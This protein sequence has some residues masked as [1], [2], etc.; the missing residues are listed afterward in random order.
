MVFNRFSDTLGRLNNLLA[1]LSE[2]T[3]PTGD[4]ESKIPP[5]KHGLNN[6]IKQ[7]IDEILDTA[8]Q[9]TQEL[10]T[11]RSQMELIVERMEEGYIAFDLEGHI[12]KLN[13]TA[14]QKILGRPASELIGISYLEAFQETIEPEFHRQFQAVCVEQRPVQFEIKWRATG[15]WLALRGYPREEQIEFFVRDISE[16]KRAEIELHS[17]ARFAEENPNPVLRIDQQG[18]VLYGNAS[19]MQLLEAH[20]CRVGGPAPEFLR[21]LALEALHDGQK[22]MA[23]YPYDGRV[24]AFTIVPFLEYGYVNLYGSDMTEHREAEEQLRVSNDRLQNVLSNITDAYF[25]L[26]DQ[27]RLVDYNAVAEQDFL[28][29]PKS[30][31]IGKGF[32][33]EFPQTIGNEHY[34][35]FHRAFET[36]QPVH[37]EAI[38]TLA[39]KWYEVHAYPRAGRL[40]IYLRNIDERKQTEN[41]LKTALSRAE[42][43]QTEALTIQDQALAAA[44]LA[45]RRERVLETVFNAM[46]EGVTLFDIQGK[47]A[48]VN[49]SARSYFGIDP[50]GLDPAA[51]LELLPMHEPDGRPLRLENLP[52][53]LALQ[54]QTVI[55]HQLRFINPHGEVYNIVASAAPLY[56]DNQL[57][58]A[59]L[60][61]RDVT[62]RE[63][64]LRRLRE[65]SERFDVAL[66]N[67]PVSVYTLD[68]DMRFTWAYKPVYNF[69]VDQML[70]RRDDELLP[71]EEVGELVAI[72]RQ[73]LESGEGK[74]TEIELALEGNKRFFD[75]TIE[76]VRGPEGV[77][78]GLTVAWIDITGQRRLEA[79]AIERIAQIEIQREILRQREQERMEVARDLHDGPLQDMIGLS[80]AL[81]DMVNTDDKTERLEKIE[82]IQQSLQSQINNIRIFCSELRP[83]ALAP[84]GVERA[85][86]A[87]LESVQ[88]KNSQIQFYLDMVKDG[89]TLPEETRMALFRV[90]QEAVNNVVKHSS[91]TDT[92]VRF[93]LDEEQVELEIRDNGQGFTRPANL[94]NLA[95][96]GHLGL[97]GMQERVE[98]VGGALEVLSMPGEG[99]RVRVTIRRKDDLALA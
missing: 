66:R 95:R 7:R 77:V 11:V 22:K 46:T 98:A 33:D 99:T 86:R 62:E 57:I 53:Q 52:A 9:S 56:I 35:Q 45:L 13:K 58:G 83:P 48:Q 73:V 82:E 26:D 51:Y 2:L 72:K 79:E 18:I 61:W 65:I 87:H 60:V 30:E 50:T 59:V 68:R 67:A 17:Q 63:Q 80:F 21:G 40:E 49:P 28:F 84:F 10:A 64:L 93:Y 89:N 41:E 69:T 20:G 27:W 39:S 91:A 85:I 24:I 96:Q 25:V 90:F 54:G 75:L 19:A 8:R 37:Y 1:E 29:R 12:L 78:S 47:I 34:R 92:W 5:D 43:A 71:P 42:I 55:D 3:H 36:G 81:T 14:E 97:V 38:S 88:E 16:Q 70:G 15:L 4:Q 32:W 23:D 31:L 44:A 6:S 76:P 74:R 94:V